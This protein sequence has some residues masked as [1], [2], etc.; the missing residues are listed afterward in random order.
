MAQVTFNQ[1]D[2]G[3]LIFYMRNR[4]LNVTQAFQ[5]ARVK[6][7]PYTWENLQLS[8]IDLMDIGVPYTGIVQ[9]LM[10]KLDSK[11]E[12]KRYSIIHNLP[13]NDLKKVV[14]PNRP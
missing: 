13:L 2:N 8:I 1:D 12:L 5:E 3:N 14:K 9:F 4:S 11:K 6:V 7:D 10:G